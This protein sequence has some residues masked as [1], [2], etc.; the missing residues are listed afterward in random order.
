M[1]PVIFLKDNAY[2]KQDRA[3]GGWSTFLYNTI[4]DLAADTQLHVAWQV[5]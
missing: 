4:S 1:V 2:N 5:L 3:G